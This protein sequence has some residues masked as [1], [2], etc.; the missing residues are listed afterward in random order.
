LIREISQRESGV[1]LEQLGLELLCPHLAIVCLV[2]ADSSQGPVFIQFVAC[3][4][5]FV[6]RSVEK[7]AFGCK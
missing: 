1:D 5:V 6:V 3:L 4:C 7:V 2:G